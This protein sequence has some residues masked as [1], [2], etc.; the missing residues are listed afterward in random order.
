MFHITQLVLVLYVPATR[1]GQPAPFDRPKTMDRALSDHVEE[2]VE[3]GLYTTKFQR[4]KIER[5]VDTNVSVKAAEILT[6]EE[7]VGLGVMW[8]GSKLADA[9][10]CSPRALFP[11]HSLHIGHVR[12][13]IASFNS[14]KTPDIPPA[15][16]PTRRKTPLPTSSALRAPPASKP[17]TS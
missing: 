5:R 15:W 1:K 17:S 3:A 14:A 2:S 16:P 4:K 11:G 9:T 7:A 8:W 12:P 6:K 10:T 13:L